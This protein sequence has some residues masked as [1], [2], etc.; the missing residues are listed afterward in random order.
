MS[1]YREADNTLTTWRP[2]C[3]CLLAQLVAVRPDVGEISAFFLSVKSPPFLNR[4]DL[5]TQ[6]YKAVHEKEI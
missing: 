4:K 3:E 5:P 1:R 2:M 6:N